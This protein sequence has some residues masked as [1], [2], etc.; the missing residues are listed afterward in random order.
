MELAEVIREIIVTANPEITN[1]SD[2]KTIY[3][4]VTAPNYA[5]YTG[6]A[7]V[8]ISKADQ[9]APAAPTKD[10]VSVN[11]ITLKTITNGEYKMGDGD[12]W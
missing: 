4:K 10:S 6:S 2:S 7:A 1:V 5:D 9:D 3:F 8:T 11:S 12:T